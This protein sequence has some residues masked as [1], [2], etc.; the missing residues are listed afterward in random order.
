[1][2]AKCNLASESQ[3]ILSS[4]FLFIPLKQLFEEQIQKI[5]KP[6]VSGQIYKKE[7]HELLVTTIVLTPQMASFNKMRQ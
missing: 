3:K 1:M 6:Q 4:I 2:K 5:T 7:Q